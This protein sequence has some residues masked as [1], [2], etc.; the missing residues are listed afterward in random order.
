MDTA[1]KRA[2]AGLW[3]VQGVGPVTLDVIRK[4]LGPLG[5][6]LE[7]PPSAWASLVDWK[8]DAYE[9]VSALPSLAVAA[10]R[11]ERRCKEMQAQILFSGDSGFPAR[12]E[13][14]PD[15]PP[16][17]FA[18]G[19]GAD[20][21]P[22]RRL[23][24][25]GTRDIAAGFAPRVEE[26]AADVG[27]CGLGVI[28]GA[29]RGIDQAAHRG[30]LKV[31]AETWAFLG[32][33]LDEIDALQRE[34]CQKILDAGGTLFTEFPPGFR[35]NLHSFILRN[36]L[37]SGA[38]DAVLVVRA[39]KKSGALNTAD[40]AKKQ[41]RPLLVTAAD[42]WDVTAEGSNELLRKGE[43]Q[44]HLGVE[45]VLHAVGITGSM[46]QAEVTMPFE[47]SELSEPARLVLQRLGRAPD[48]F[49]GLQCAFPALTSGEI[50]AALVELEVFGAVLHKGGRH[51]EKR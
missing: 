36:R 11:V 25:V 37:I 44:L 15:A 23:A 51:Y 33:A 43:A 30:A 38:S 39:P 3:S 19:P 6:L 10:D 17:L 46:S 45:D 50:S 40:N 22:R 41:G 9:R 35:S 14:I 4:R 18:F 28:S 48:D 26:I 13:G 47:L 29:A 2:T 27:L 7:K 34:I 12:L 24:I 31:G 49:E 5:D 32:S 16:M 1:E 8:G 21:P 20:A 42:P